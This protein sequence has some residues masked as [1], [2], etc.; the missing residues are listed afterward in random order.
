LTAASDGER[1]QAELAGLRHALD[2]M[3]AYI[4]V[5]DLEG[6]Y[7]YAN[8]LVCQLFGAAPEGVIGHDDGDFFDLERS[9]QL[10]AVDRLVLD[11]GQTLERE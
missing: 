5:K 10:K 3:G 2:T 1:L 11:M 7:T 4:Y 8:R 9:T 6:R